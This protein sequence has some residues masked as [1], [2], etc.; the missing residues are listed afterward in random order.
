MPTYTTRFALERIQT[1]TAGWNPVFTVPNDGNVYVLRD[2]C[3]WNEL[4]TANDLVVGVRSGSLDAW[5]FGS[6]AF[7]GTQTQHL[8]LRQVLLAGEVLELYLGAN[9]SAGVMLTGYRLVGP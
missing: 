4:T 5:L 1:A 6:F 8:E 2:V 9:S 7:P 3:V